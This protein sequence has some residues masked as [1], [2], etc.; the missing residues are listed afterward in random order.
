MYKK[1][2]DNL[3]ELPR[4]LLLYGDEFYLKMY[5]EKLLKRFENANVL[6]LYYDEY[7]YEAAKRHL[8]E[9][10]L[11]G[12]EN[13][14][15]IKHNKIPQ[16]IEKLKDYAKNGYLF[17]FYTGDKKPA[18]FGKNFVRFFAPNLKEVV[19]YIQELEKKYNITLTKEARLFLAKTT[20]ALFLE[21]E[22]EKLSLYD[23]EM[24]LE[25]VRK[26]VFL[27]KEESFEDL[28]VDILEGRE[29]FDKLQNF[30]E[31][32]DF[33]RIIPAFIRYVRE[34]IEYRLYIKTTGANTLDGYLGYRLPKDIEQKRIY[35]AVSIKENLLFELLKKLLL[36]ELQMR[37]SNRDKEALFWEAMSFLRG[38][39]DRF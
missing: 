10:S 7:D 1:E 12:G 34:L 27:Y 33:R 22:I 17:F 26:L 19:L 14:L 28:I 13:V 15:I 3:K 39:K 25:D 21:K 32:T 16:N 18:V 30:L 37:N 35:L 9:I 24:G 31:I 2:F 11:F 38:F 36:Y 5:E 29:F 20:E 23:S 6:K 4:Y 8:S